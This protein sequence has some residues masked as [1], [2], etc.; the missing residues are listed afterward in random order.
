MSKSTNASIAVDDTRRQ[1]ALAIAEQ[2]RQVLKQEFRA[3]SVIVFGSLRG[4]TPWH[5]AS[6]L[7]LAVEGLEPEAFYRAYEALEALI[8]E[9]LPFDLVALEQADEHVC[10]RILQRTPM[11]RNPYLATKTRLDDE[12]RLL[13]KTVTQSETLLA[14]ADSIPEI[15]LIP[16]AAAY[17]EDF[18][19]GCER[20]AERVAVMLDG[21][22]PTGENWHRQLLEQV[23]Q[24]SEQGRLPLWKE[25]LRQEL[26]TYRRFR[27]RAR[28]LYRADLDREKVLAMAQ[29]VPPVF[30]QI[31]QSLAQLAIWLTQRASQ[32]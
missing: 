11:P 30:E 1:A 17:I 8:P 6:D 18:Y 13:A 24:P 10:D 31:Q 29:Q 19:T 4:D 20:L 28:H 15:A 21:K 23:S 3:T 32:N 14:Q 9:W 5:G 16:A 25:S 2:C 27:H 12:M 7:D 26:D 22:L